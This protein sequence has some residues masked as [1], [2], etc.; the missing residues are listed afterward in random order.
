MINVTEIFLQPRNV[1]P[2]IKQ[3]EM[4]MYGLDQ[5]LFIL[6]ISGPIELPPRKVEY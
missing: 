3:F 4:N 5:V 6:F 2:L 1:I